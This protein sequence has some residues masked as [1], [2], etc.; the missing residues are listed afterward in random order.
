MHLVLAVAVRSS[1][2]GWEHGH[3]GP[4]VGREVAVAT[5]GAPGDVLALL[6]DGDLSAAKEGLAE[7]EGFVD[8]LDFRELDVRISTQFS[9]L[10]YPSGCPVMG[11]RLIVTRVIPPQEAK[12]S[13]SMLLST[14]Y[15]TF[16]T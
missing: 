12:C 4:H 15:S 1:A 9:R 6:L 10:C 11:S 16:F 2:V 8:G 5:F 3:A 14:L 13:F 7:F